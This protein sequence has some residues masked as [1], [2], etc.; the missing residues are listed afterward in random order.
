MCMYTRVHIHIYFRIIKGKD[1]GKTR[2][3][4]VK[5]GNLRYLKYT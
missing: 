1:V 4:T 3:V 2:L 5:Y